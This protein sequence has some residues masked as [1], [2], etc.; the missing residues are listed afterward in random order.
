MYMDIKKNAVNY[1]K[2]QGF[3]LVELMITVAILGILTAIAL[4]SY[5]QYV[6][7]SHRA[8]AKTVLLEAAAHM[9]RFYSENFRYDQ[10]TG[11]T[12]VAL[13]TN[14]LRSPKEIGSAQQYA[15][16]V[17]AAQRTYTLSATRSTG[18]AMENDPC[19]NFTINQ[20]GLK[21]LTSA[22]SGETVASCWA[23]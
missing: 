10:D 16:T 12:A 13:P 1:L 15:V 14:L 8:E 17:V 4:P 7:R 21:A 23:K 5:Q 9:E 6:A 22:A 3:T 18:S 11:G 2:L 20:N 19:G